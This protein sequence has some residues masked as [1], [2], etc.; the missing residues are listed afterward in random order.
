V[1]INVMEGV[2]VSDLP[3]LLAS[4]PYVVI[5]IMEGVTASDVPYAG[6]SSCDLQQTGS[7]SV[8]D[9]QAL[10]NEALGMRAP[11][12]DLN[13]DLKVNVVDVEIE[14]NGALGLGCVAY[15]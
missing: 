13:G 1:A 9:V 5:N 11:V 15:H 8:T 3:K 7:V 6:F 12:D 4:A 2:T 10:I 14:I